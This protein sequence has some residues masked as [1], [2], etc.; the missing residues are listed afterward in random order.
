MLTDIYKKASMTYLPNIRTVKNGG[1]GM[2]H[3][4]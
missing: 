4:G 1:G 2:A 3:A